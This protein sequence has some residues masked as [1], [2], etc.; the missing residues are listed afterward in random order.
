MGYS[1]KISIIEWIVLRQTHDIKD[2]APVWPAT[3][4]ECS[5]PSH[6]YVNSILSYKI[7]TRKVIDEDL[8]HKHGTLS[9][10]SSLKKS[11]ASLSFA[12]FFFILL[13]FYIQTLVE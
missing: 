12:I 3:C 8:G 13:E 2:C 5:V 10:G 9:H 7:A 1:W 4:S 11:G 6:F